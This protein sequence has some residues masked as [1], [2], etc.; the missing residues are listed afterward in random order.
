MIPAL[1]KAKVVVTRDRGLIGGGCAI[2]V[3]CDG[4]LV[5]GIKTEEK[6]VLHL[7]PGEHII[8]AKHGGGICGGGV[9]QTE[10]DATLAKPR[11]LRIAIGQSGDIKIEPSAY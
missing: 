9:D 1:D 8:G 7:S 6:V 4:T 3:Y 2:Q 10:I 5:A 11:S